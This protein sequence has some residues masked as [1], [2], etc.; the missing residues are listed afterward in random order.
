MDIHY[1]LTLFPMEALIASHHEPHRFGAYMAVGAR[2]GSAERLIFAELNDCGF[3]GIDWDHARDNCVPHSNGSP[4]NSV[5]LSIYR[6]LETV[7]LDAIGSIYLT[8][9][10]GRSLELPP[11]EFVAAETP[12]NYYVYQELCPIH[13]LVVSRLEPGDF[14]RYITREN[15]QLHVPKIAFA[16]LKVIDLDN[17]E[18]TGNIGAFYDRNVC[19][20]QACVRSV[21]GPP[22]KRSKTLNR[23]HIESFSFNI[24]G[25]A[26]YISEGERTRSYPM[27]AH[28]DMLDTHYRWARSAMIL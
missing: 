10:D 24:L 12:A 2:R 1:Y 6:V 18:D 17:L 25:R 23:S 13:P 22:G 28:D 21:I 14:G 16:N 3:D 11:Q 9:R 15:R 5:Y 20:L 27:P 4:K 7:P 8:T 19:H 26:I